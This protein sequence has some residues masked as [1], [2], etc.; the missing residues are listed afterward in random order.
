MVRIRRYAKEVHI[1]REVVKKSMSPIEGEIISIKSDE[2]VQKRMYRLVENA[3]RLV[4][5]YVF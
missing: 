1:V 5:E 4:K 3:M 2:G